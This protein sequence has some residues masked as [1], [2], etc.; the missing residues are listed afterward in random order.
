MQGLRGT[1]RT[2]GPW[3]AAAA[4]ALPAGVIART[5]TP[6][7]ADPSHGTAAQVVTTQPQVTGL[8]FDPATAGQGFNFQIAA[9]GLFGFYYGYHDGTPLWLIFDV[10]PGAVSVGQTMTLDARVPQAGVFGNP[11]PPDQ[12]GIAPWGTLELRFDTCTRAYARLDGVTGSQE[13][14][15]V[16]LA[17]MDGIDADDCAAAGAARPL[18]D[19][20]GAW[21]DPATAGQGWNFVQ[22]P[23]GL[24]AFFYGYDE[25]G[26]P[27]WLLTEQVLDMTL[28]VAQAFD[29]LSGQGGSFDV[30]VPPEA[31]QRWGTVELELAS[32]RSGVAR[33]A[34]VDGDQVQALQMLAGVPGTPACSE[35]ARFAWLNDSGIQFCGGMSSGN[36]TPC[37]PA[38]P[39]GQDAHYG[40]DA[41]AATGALEKVGGG[42]AGFDFTKLSHAGQTL[43]ASAPLG[44]AADDWACTRD[45][46]TGLV[47][48]VKVNNASH[49][50]H[51][52]HDYTWFV[53][54]S[55]DG[56]PG[57][58]GTGGTCNQTL[59]EQPCN[60]DVFVQA[61]NAAALCGRSDWRLPT[62]HELESIM[63]Y[64][65][66]RPA[67]DPTYFTN[68]AAAPYWTGLPRADSANEAWA[69]FFDIG[70]VDYLPRVSARKVRLVS[71]SGVAR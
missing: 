41:L 13:F 51:V 36:F 65:R 55:P 34:G 11:A 38:Q 4:F 43:S 33:I 28:G 24:V 71:A 50:R 49:L 2:W 39:P 5:D 9:G 67:I 47:W 53:P 21:F 27:L 66:T 52:L 30:P 22:T 20:T 58:I 23:G 56:Q 37:T 18:A 14:D 57:V 35:P 45:N 6:L 26:E 1:N 8:W 62:R 19:A 64:G 25:A 40:R 60:T 69:A 42:D 68:T 7:Q 31:L 10:H 16:L 29:L 59:G 44:P 15:L 70:G 54:N 46:V 48:E 17:G 12:G 32:C 3:I 61:V 63:H